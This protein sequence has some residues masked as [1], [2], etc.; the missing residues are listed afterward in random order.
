MIESRL[1]QQLAAIQNIDIIAALMP[2]GNVLKQAAVEI[3]PVDTGHLRDSITVEE[4]PP[5]EHGI[6]VYA[7]AGEYDVDY[8]CFVEFGTSNPNYPI[9]PYMRPALDENQDAMNRAVA[10]DIQRQL[11]DLIRG[12]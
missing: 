4:L 6:M 5:S 9:Q 12:A 11:N 10:L 2:A 7:G 8:A 3:V 1:N